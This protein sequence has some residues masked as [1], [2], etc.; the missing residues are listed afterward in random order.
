V[1]PAEASWAQPDLDHAAALMRRVYD[2][3]AAS[4]RISDAALLRMKH[5]PGRQEVA[6]LIAS[7]VGIRH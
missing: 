4:K 3:P 6:E 1:Y 5:Q 2:A 7:L